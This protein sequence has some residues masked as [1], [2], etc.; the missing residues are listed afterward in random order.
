MRVR[1][2]YCTCKPTCLTR[3]LIMTCTKTGKITVKGL[4]LHNI[5]EKLV[6]PVDLTKKGVSSKFKEI[7]ENLIFNHNIF[8]P[9][10]IYTKLLLDYHNETP[11]LIQIQ[12]YI[13]Y[14]RKKVGDIYI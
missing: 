6:V 7:I 3:Y 9:Y 2:P 8:K 10:S 12:N 1:Y 4:N 13:K 5:E 11:S 14:R